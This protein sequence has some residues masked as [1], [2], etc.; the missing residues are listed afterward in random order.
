M[1]FNDLLKSKTGKFISI[2]FGQ[3]FVKVIYAQK[4]NKEF[5]LIAYDLKKAVLNEENIPQ[6]ADFITSFLKRNSVSTRNA[7]LTISDPNCIIIKST[8]LPQLPKNEILK[9]LQ[10]QLK[11]ELNINFKDVLLEWRL[12]KEYTDQDGS[13]KQE[14]MVSCLKNI[15]QYLLISRR[16]NLTPLGITTTS[17]NYANILKCSEQDTHI[18][19][20]LDIGSADSVLSIYSD[21]KLAFIR[22]LAFSTEKVTQSLMDALLTSKG[23]VKLSYEKAEEIRN[24]FGIPMDESA[25]LEENVAAMHVISLMRPLL[26]LLVRE[27]KASLDYFATNYK[28]DSPTV[29]YITGGGANLKNL[30]KYLNKELNITVSALPFP[31]CVNAIS[32][33]LQTLDSDKNQLMN[34]LGAILV[35]P[36]SIDFI[37][38]EVKIQRIEPI[39]KGF[40]RLLAFTASV[41]LIASYYLLNLQISYYKKR[42]NNSLVILQKMGDVRTA[43]ERVNP[44]E[45]IVYEIKKYNVPAEGILKFLSKA[46]PGSIILDELILDQKN[47]SLILKGVVNLDRNKQVSDLTQTLASL[48]TSPFF[49]KAALVSSKAEGEIEAFEIN[50]ELVY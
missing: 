8:V 9:A 41:F 17:F 22:R 36:E 20:I 21:N 30:G 26:E 47:N 16:C 28:E 19:A 2:D 25:I 10:W 12:V 33:Q 43:I 5:R 23:P 18:Q 31:P 45:D 6:I 13:N 39:E 11:E 42:L 27:L 44:L 46:L 1:N 15:D 48:N 50:C 38:V 24:K 32:A 14:I 3:L 34:A 29:L 49:K 35:G 37:P 7:Y 4:Y 40:L